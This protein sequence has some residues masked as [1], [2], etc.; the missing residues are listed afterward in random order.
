MDIWW[1]LQKFDSSS[2]ELLLKPYSDD[3]RAP[4]NESINY[5]DKCLR[6]TF[7][8][9]LRMLISF[10]ITSPI[11]SQNALNTQPKNISILTFKHFRRPWLSMFEL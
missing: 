10:G 2:I 7:Q 1:N 4:V 11:I 9:K 8:T 3:L 5:D 6:H